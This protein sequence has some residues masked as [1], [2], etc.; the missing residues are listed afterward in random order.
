[1]FYSTRF[2]PHHFFP[3]FSC[4]TDRKL[5]KK[6]IGVSVLKWIGPHLA[7]VTMFNTGSGSPMRGCGL[8][9]LVARWGGGGGLG[10]RRWDK[11]TSGL[12]PGTSVK[13]GKAGRLVGS[14]YL[15]NRRGSLC[16]SG[17]NCLTPHPSPLL[18]V[19]WDLPLP[20]VEFRERKLRHCP[21]ALALDETPHSNQ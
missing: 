19:L 18:Q 16:A 2:R 13:A 14:C 17:G 10:M 4:R 9:G 7:F 15:G 3:L 11:Q 21:Q 1:M 8:V 20:T 6:I 5:P 12:K